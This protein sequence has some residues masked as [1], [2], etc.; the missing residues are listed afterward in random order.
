MIPDLARAALAIRFGSLDV[1]AREKLKLLVLANICVAVA[2]VPGVRLPQPDSGERHFL[3]GG[4]R[5]ARAVDAA[6]FNAAAMHARTQDDFHPVGNLHLGTV[7]LPAVL[8]A[9]E[10]HHCTGEEL[11]DAIATGYMVA[12]ALSRPNSVVTTPKGLRSTGIYT[13]FGATAAAGR[14]TGLSQIEMESA[15]AI[16]AS[17]ACGLTQCWADGSDE[18]QLHVATA[19]ETGLRSC[20]LARHGFVGGR[21]ALDG[22]AGF[23]N[24]MVGRSTAFETIADDLTTGTAI[25]ETIMKR[26]PVSGICQP[27]TF[28]T[29]RMAAAS[30]IDPNQISAVHIEMN[31]FEMRYSG[32]LN[33]G[34]YHSF[35]DVLMSAAYCCSAV[36]HRGSLQFEDLLQRGD[37][38]RDRLI[39]LTEVTDD[40]EL[41]FMSAR[42]SVT[43]RDGSVIRDEVRAIG[44]LLGISW[45]DV[46]DWG[47]ALW[48][49]RDLYTHCRDA[50]ATLEQR[51][52]SELLATLSGQ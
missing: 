20:A 14:L 28:L 1:E 44:G 30:K 25:T 19:A 38:A 49:N 40:P 23:F 34:P 37:P 46:D 29:E 22:K 13:P 8:A 2:G 3:F 15:L 5:T 47:A 11:L 32:T 33:K 43:L 50:V 12:V 52:A 36:L 18:W 7:I 31:P 9:A 41:P 10:T 4:M 35:S 16:T 24:A 51:Q 6:S 17:L 26:Y 45:S 39:A 42:L 21:H 48:G 27:L